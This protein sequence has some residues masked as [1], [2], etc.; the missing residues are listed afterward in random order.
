[1]PGFALT[2]QQIAFMA[3]FGYLRI[4]GLMR[5]A[6]ATI[7]PAFDQVLAEHGGGAYAGEHRLTV[8]GGLACSGPLAR[9]M[10]DAKPMIGLLTSLLGEDYQ[11]WASEISYCGGD[12]PWHTDSSPQPEWRMP[13]WY[14]VFVYPDALDASNGALRVI[15]GSHRF[16]DAYAADIQR[17]ILAEDGRSWVD[18]GAHWGAGGADVPAVTL[19]S[20]PGDVIIIN[21]MTAHASF[22]GA[23]R[24]RL[25]TARFFPALPGDRLDLLERLVRRRGYT[26]EELFGEDS[27]LVRGAPA[28]RRRHFRQLLALLPEEG[29]AD[30]ARGE[31]ALAGP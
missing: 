2:P 26:R 15:P 8:P 10:L 27:M 19:A 14:Q 11:Y 22:G 17:G 6:M 18:P 20:R 29:H 4:P 13:E 7:G 31:P 5:D 21:Y 9:A 25:L 3:T 23:D 16:N 28:G 1:M 24:R 30:R 12:T